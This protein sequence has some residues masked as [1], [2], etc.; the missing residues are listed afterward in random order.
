MKGPSLVLIAFLLCCSGGV[1]GQLKP[2]DSVLFYLDQVKGLQHNDSLHL[3]EANRVIN[4]G[5]LT[6]SDVEKVERK[7]TRLAPVI[8]QQNVLALKRLIFRSIEI[9]KNPEYSITYGKRLVEELKEYSTEFEKNL[10]MNVLADLRI[11]YRNS[12]KIHQGIEYFQLNA[13]YFEHLNDS[14]ATSQCYYVLRGFYEV[15]GLTDKAVYCQMKSIGFLNNNQVNQFSGFLEMRSDDI[16]LLAVINRK[17][18]LAGML[19]DW[20]E[21]Q[22]AFPYLYETK[23]IYEKLKDSTLV[24][25][26]PNIYLQM[27]RAKIL[28]HGD[29]IEWYFSLMKKDL[30]GLDENDYDANYYQVR[31]YYFYLQNKLDSAEYN[32]QQSAAIKDSTNLMTNSYFGYLTPGYFHALI[33]LRQNKY[34]EAIGL[35]KSEIQELFKVNL[36]PLVLRNYLLLNNAYKLSG[37]FKN[38]TNIL[39]QYIT[40]QSQ[41]IADENKSRSASYETEQKI[42]IL[43]IQQER[44]QVE[45]DRQKLIKNL[46]ASG[47][48]LVFL[49]SII[50]LVQ[51]NRISKE[52]NRSDNLLLNILPL[53][54]AEEL[55]SKGSA[56][57]KHYDEVTVMFTDFKNF[58]QATEKLSA[59]ELVKEIH[60][61]YSRF[62][63]IITKYN[64]EKIKTIG[65]SYMCAGGLPVPN[66]TNAIDT[67]NAALEMQ[68][69]FS[70]H[71]VANSLLGNAGVGLRIGCH[72]GPVV[73][74][75]VG[76][77]KF[78]YDI[79]G[80]TVNIASRME[81]SGEAGKVNISGETYNRVKGQFKCIHRG[82]ILAK[83]K[84]DVDM[85]FIDFI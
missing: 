38:A 16:G 46:I 51:R 17:V 84:G 69:F 13:N 76:I 80:D 15:L 42:N 57:A 10:L 78:A 71:L 64:L 72:T 4:S 25:D 79:W 48:V 34:D 62:D 77:K 66:N 61:C 52:K 59:S 28:T 3:T 55:K 22:K 73:A 20:N 75:I 26:G 44:Q 45:I 53:E 50:T 24:I 54:T 27:I 33:K 29:S 23:N 39:E 56:D 49:F 11:P 32:I 7:L 67:V 58:T 14:D 19:N 65:D 40:L 68:Q 43:N 70:Q 6:V 21:A 5:T 81:S 36:R 37:D 9:E 82:K 83:N 31:S 1:H 41:I 74:G 63:E 60:H 2:A 30:E 35:L 8:G 47:L 85:Y 18:V 12:N